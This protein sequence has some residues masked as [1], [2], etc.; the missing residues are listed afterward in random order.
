M[1]EAA[2]IPLLTEQ[3][4]LQGE[5]LAAVRHEYLGGTVH[6]MAGGTQRHNLLGARVVAFLTSHLRGGPCRP[7]G[8]DMRVRVETPRDTRFYYPDAVVTCDPR[9]TEPLFLQ[10]P[11]LVV[12]ILSP[13]TE[14]ADLREKWSAYPSLPTLEE[15]LVLAQDSARA[16]LHRRAG[17]WAPQTFL[18]PSAIVPLDSL[19]LRLPLADIYEAL[20]I[21]GPNGSLS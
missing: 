9:D 3:E 17:S 2:A 12:E 19:G 14:A 18:S 4:Y 6:A 15:Y 8:S 5:D 16:I 10:F 21:P 1:S 7:F 20:D 11:K 13:S